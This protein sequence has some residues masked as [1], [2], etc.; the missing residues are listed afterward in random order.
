MLPILTAIMSKWFGK[1]FVMKLR[2]I[3]LLLM[4]CGCNGL[5]MAQER[6]NDPKMPTLWIIGDSTVRNSTKGQV[7]WGDPIAELFDRTRI[8]VENRALGG[9]SSRTF[10]TQGLWDQVL[11]EVKPGDFVLM[12]F[13]HNDSSAVN[14]DSRARGTLKGLGEETEEIDNILTKK[15]ETVHTYGWYMR[16]YIDD[17]KSKGAIAIVLSPVPRNMW[18]NGKVRR[19]AGDYGGWAAAVAKSQGAYFLDLNELVARRYEAIGADKVKELYFLEDHT[20][21][22]LAGAQLTAEI[23]VA[24]LRGLKGC[25]L[26]KY[27]LKQRS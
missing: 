26:K 23:V 24:G 7:G 20:H 4:L 11:A 27:L 13:G 2:P 6:R 14:D 8:R 3:W 9:R 16:K 21:T 5:V 18:E 19:A 25:Q 22:T 12:Q 15:H 10:Q 1:M 17:T